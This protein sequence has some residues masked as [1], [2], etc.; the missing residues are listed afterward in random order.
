MQMRLLLYSIVC[1]LLISTGMATEYEFEAGSY[2]VKFNSSQEL[3]IQPP[4]ANEESGSYATGWE[5]R[6]QD[7]IGHQ[8]A[9]INIVEEDKIVPVNDELIDSILDNNFKQLPE[10]KPKTT[11]KI[12]GV[13]GRM[14]KGYDSSWGMNTKEAIYPLNSLYDPFY[15]QNATKHF[16]V[17]L[18]IDL[19]VYDEI[20]ESLNITTN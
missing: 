5:T 10:P 14:I 2:T 12:D 16:V 7:N 17:L 13:N 20:I 19:P 3:V 1:A 9:L 11:I 8:I 15:K 18:G 4:M 6:I